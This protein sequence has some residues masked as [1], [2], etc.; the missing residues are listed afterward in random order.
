VGPEPRASRPYRVLLTTWQS[1]GAGSVQSVQYLARGLRA[2]GHRVHVACPAEGVLGR[3]LR[4][5]GVPVVPME[6]PGGWSVRAGRALSRV[7]RELGVELVDAQE[8]RDRKAAILARYLYG[9]PVRLVITRRQM[10]ATFPLQNALYSAAADRVIA[11]SEGVARDLVRRGMSR[12]KIT[13]VHTGLDPRRV[14]GEIPAEEVEALRRELALDPALPTVGVVARRKDQETL[15]RGLAALG[16]PVNALFVGIDRDPALA[17]LEPG[18]P[19]GSRV[20]YA[21]FRERVLPFYRLLDVM[22]L[23]TLREG[24]SQAILEAMALGVPVVSAAAGGTPEVV[25]PGVSGLLFPPGDGDA[26]ASELAR[27]LDDPALRQRVASGGR[28]TVREEF[29]AD[30]LVRGTEAVYRRLLEAAG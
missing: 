21:G 12:R 27:L 11:I 18:L 9:A 26:L 6:F 15:L 19:A 7:I 29:H 25:R 3:R 10:T 13:V 16:R 2:R 14:D 22:V 30:A 20:A 1:K 8:S 4:E 23:T 28:E 17:A 5:E 24:L